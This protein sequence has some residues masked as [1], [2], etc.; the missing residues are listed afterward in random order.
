M[1][2]RT[3]SFVSHRWL[4]ALEEVRKLF[5]FFVG[6]LE[7]SIDSTYECLDMGW[8]CS[9]LMLCFPQ[10]VSDFTP[11]G[12]REFNQLIDCVSVLCKGDVGNMACL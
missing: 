7:D 2:S 5:L 8:D 11:S 3:L 12:N 4:E 6:S 10:L 1:G 9:S